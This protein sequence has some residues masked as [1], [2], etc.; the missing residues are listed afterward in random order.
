VLHLVLMSFGFKSGLPAV[1]D[2]VFDTPLPRQPLRRPRRCA[3]LRPRCPGRRLRAR[4][5][6]AAGA[7]RPRRGLLR[8]VVPRSV[9][10][11]R[12]YLT[13]A[14]GCTG[15]QHRSVA[16]SRPSRPP[17]RSGSRCRA[18]R[19]RSVVARHRDLADPAARGGDRAWLTPAVGSA[20]CWSATAAAPARCS[21]AAEGIVGEAAFAGVVAVDAGAGETPT[22]R[23]RM[24]D[25]AIVAADAGAGVL[26]VADVFGASP[27][28]CGIRRPI[29]PPARGARGPQPGDVAQAG[30]A[31]PR[32]AVADRAR[33]GVRRVGPPR[34]RRAPRAR[35]AKLPERSPPATT[36][37][38]TDLNEE[39]A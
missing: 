38:T 17:P 29:G 30:D 15:G 14:L 33:P 18:C 21:R 23:G 1:A 9:R 10:E 22:L 24:C 19:R 2:L 35:G 34:G 3:P 28:S 5:P 16:L 11:G 6:D 32:R 13:V 25:A 12:S 39:P 36:P 26:L 4:Q 31:R 8:F 27:C 37:A 20:S 7:A